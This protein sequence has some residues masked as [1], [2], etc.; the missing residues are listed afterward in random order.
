MSYCD[1]YISNTNKLSMVVNDSILY[2]G[3]DSLSNIFYGL[4]NG[5]AITM[6]SFKNRTSYYKY[7]ISI[8]FN[9]YRKMYLINSNNNNNNKEK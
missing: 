5:V 2:T 4:I 3:T 1:L 8:L 9:N 7:I 6:T